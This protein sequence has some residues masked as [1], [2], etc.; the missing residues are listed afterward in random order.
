MARIALTLFESCAITAQPPLAD[1]PFSVYLTPASAEQFFKSCLTALQVHGEHQEIQGLLVALTYALYDKSP[2]EFK[3]LYC[4]ILLQIPNVNRK[5]FD[6]FLHKCGS[7]VV[8]GSGGNVDRMK[9]DMFKRLVQPVVGKN[10]GQLYKNEIKIRV[11]EPLM[12]SSTKRKF[13]DAEVEF[14]IC[15]LFDPN[16]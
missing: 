16:Y 13:N 12:L 11:L 4:K 10:L 3:Q 9:K 5:L 15:S 7:Q 2:G 8:N 14:N 6:D 1:S